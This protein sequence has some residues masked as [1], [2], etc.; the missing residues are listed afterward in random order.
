MDEFE[1]D[2]EECGVG[3]LIH[4][5]EVPDFCPLCGAQAQVIILNTDDEKD[6]NY[7]E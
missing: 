5:Y 6:L 7:D 2:C 3:S 1:I 4:S